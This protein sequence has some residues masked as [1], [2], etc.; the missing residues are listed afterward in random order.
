VHHA[1]LGV[2]RTQASRQLDRRDAEPGYDGNMVIDARYPEGQLLGWTP[3]QAPHASPAGMPWRLEP[4]SDLVVQ[5]HLQPTG[6]V[7]TLRASV[8]VFFTDTPPARTPIGLRLGSE[9]I[10]IPPGEHA[11][12]IAD[13]YTVPVDLDVLAVQPHAHNLARRMEADA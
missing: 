2:D 11:Y 9:T 5:L 6:K 7:E 8:G 3:G 10:D 12:A 13:R 4:G 1:N